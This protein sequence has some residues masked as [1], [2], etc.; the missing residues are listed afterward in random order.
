MT[1]PPAARTEWLLS[2]DTSMNRGKLRSAWGLALAVLFGSVTA[3]AQPPAPVVPAKAL[4]EGGSKYR[5][6]EYPP[7]PAGPATPHQP[8]PAPGAEPATPHNDHGG[9]D[10][11]P[12]GHGES[13]QHEDDHNAFVALG[14]YLLIRPRRREQDYAIV[15]RTRTGGRSAP[16]RIS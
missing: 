16:S 2:G 9:K 8:L 1:P 3:Q 7:R 13:A 5:T 11:A 10:H 6:T 4:T 14:E 15:G 12:N